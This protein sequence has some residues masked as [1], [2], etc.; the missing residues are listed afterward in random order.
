[1]LSEI[2]P[3]GGLERI[4]LADVVPLPA[5]FTL[6]VFPTT[7]CNFRCVY[8]GHSL[9]HAEMRRQYGF[10]PQQ[11]TMETYRTVIEQAAG[12]PQKLKVLSLTGH[13][14]PLLNPHIVD[15]VRIAKE[16][17]IAERIEI[18]TNA[19]LLTCDLADGLIGA[20]LDCLRVS[21]QG[22]TDDKY[23]EV[24]GCELSFAQ[25]TENLRYFYLHRGE[26]RL[27]VK[28]MDVALD[29][30]AE[31]QLFYSTFGEISDRMFIEQ[32]RPVYTNVP[33]TEQIATTADR[34]GREHT[35]RKVC[36]LCFFML[37]VFPDGDVEPCDTIYKPVVLGNVHRE[38]LLAMW[39]GETLRNFRLEQLEKHRDRHPKCGCCC[40]PDDVSHPEDALDDY[41]EE[42]RNR[43]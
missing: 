37:G 15:M 42:L 28:V 14:E 21:L 11:M 18:I 43:I 26:C 29:G 8:C 31:Q 25:L 6:F 34:Y 30:E 2:K 38:N 22:M 17:Q 27:H 7:Y 19:S 35:P 36:P 13:G 1:M 40:A 39:Q 3:I 33:F 24:C 16:A 23:R 32:C 9:G 10:V 20:G 12:F 4:R 41:C 5:P